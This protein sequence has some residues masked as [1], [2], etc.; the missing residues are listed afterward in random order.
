MRLSLN[1]L[2]LNDKKSKCVMFNLRA[3]LAV[4]HPLKF[5]NFVFQQVSSLTY[6]GTIINSQLN[7]HSHFNAIRDKVVANTLS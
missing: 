1:K 7:C 4:L 6:L 5:N 3:Q 2:A